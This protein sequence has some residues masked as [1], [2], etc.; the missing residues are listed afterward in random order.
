MRSQSHDTPGKPGA[1]R[2]WYVY[3]PPREPLAL[4]VKDTAEAILVID[5]LSERDLK[6]DHISSNAMGLEVWEDSEWCEWQDPNGKDIRELSD[7][8]EAG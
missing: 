8:R 1:L 6:D 5:A 3:N 2:V 7:E 4:P